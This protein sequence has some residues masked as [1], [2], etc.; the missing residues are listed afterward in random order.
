MVEDDTA[1]TGK[2]QSVDVLAGFYS[3]YGGEEGRAPVQRGAIATEL[4]V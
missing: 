2:S 4:C 3:E 1:E